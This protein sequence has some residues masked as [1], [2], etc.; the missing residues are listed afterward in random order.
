MKTMMIGRVR[1]TDPA[2]R[3]VAGVSMFFSCDTPSETVQLLRSSTRN[4]SA[5]R[6][7]FHA[8]MNTK[9]PVAAIAGMASG[10]VILRMISKRVAPSTSAAS[11]SETGTVS[12]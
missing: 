5:N 1:I 7:S 4:S 8:I 12:K 3:V 2:I 9:S 11:S 10:S 6:N